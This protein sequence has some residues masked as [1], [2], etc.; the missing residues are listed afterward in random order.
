MPMH[1]KRIKK[2]TMPNPHT[3]LSTIR[4]SVIVPTIGKRSSLADC[5]Y[6]LAKQ[7]LLPG[8]VIVADNSPNRQAY[9]IVRKM[10][11][12]L[13]FNLRYIHERKTGAG[14]ARNSGIKKS[15]YS[16][17][18][19][20]DDDCRAVKSW[21]M[22][23]LTEYVRQG[24]KKLIVQ[25][26]NENGLPH[27]FFATLNHYKDELYLRSGIYNAFTGE[28][29]AW[30]D[31]KNFLIPRALYTSGTLRFRGMD[32]ED[33]DF[34]VQAIK[35]QIP[36]V[37]CEKAVT[38]HYGRTDLFKSVIRWVLMG[39]GRYSLL[40]NSLRDNVFFYQTQKSGGSE[41]DRRTKQVERRLSNSIEEMKNPFY[42]TVFYAFYR[43]SICITELTFR[44]VL[45]AK[46]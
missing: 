26:G 43:M 45:L 2:K 13:P 10:A 18:A 24:K 30:F 39:K 8:E 19:F 37:K 14:N 38:L 44:I 5:L 21:L 35:R 42:K 36:I 29:Q 16:L 27:N 33:R 32:F 41:T 31:S 3:V 20:I 15:A 7:T 46:S 17:L 23:L 9:P 11:K 34:T 22:E 28:Y 12:E 1:M 4:I 40:E 25:G 6:A